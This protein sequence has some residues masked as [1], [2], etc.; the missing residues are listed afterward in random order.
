MCCTLGKMCWTLGRTIKFR[1]YL[2]LRNVH[3]SKAFARH[4]N[5]FVSFRKACW[6]F[7]RIILIY[8]G[9]LRIY[10]ITAKDDPWKPKNGPKIETAIPRSHSAFQNVA[11]PRKRTPRWGNFRVP[12]ILSRHDTVGGCEFSVRGTVF[13]FIF[14]FLP[15]HLKNWI[16]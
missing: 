7:Q 5:T 3:F 4:R 12:L 8:G 1:S 16:F 6:V 9:S 15:Q 14:A 13:I 10:S 11:A 2:N